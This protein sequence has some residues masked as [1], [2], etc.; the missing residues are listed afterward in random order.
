MAKPGCQWPNKQ[1]G[2][3]LFSARRQWQAAAWFGSVVLV[4]ACGLM[5][6]GPLLA[7]EEGV[8]RANLAVIYPDIGEPYRSVFGAIIEGVEDRARGKV[9]GISIPMAGNRPGISE[10]LRKR[11]VK[12]V[13]ALG[14]SGLK[15]AA[16]LDKQFTVVAGGVLSVPE[17]EAQSMLVQ[18][19]APEPALLFA[20]LKAFAPFVKRVVVVH[21]PR[22]N[23]WLIRLAREAARAQSL[24]LVALEAEDLKSAVRRYQE[25]LGSLH[26]KRDALWLPQDTTTVEDSTV[27]PL[28]LRES[29]GQNLVV[30]SSNA[31]HVRRGVLFSLYPD[32][33]EIGRFLAGAALAPL[34]PGG[35]A[36]RGIQALKQ[37]LTAVNTRTAEH[38]GLDLG[39]SQQRIHLVFPEQ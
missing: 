38:L 18:S 37:V 30:F 2:S 39:A 3:F 17:S 15:A 29:W 9:S 4:L 26:P 27:L 35:Q 28:V 33:V 1:L 7:A 12:A 13:I 25:Q 8:G 11:D 22:Q 32:N 10:E 31:M 6:A 23:D 16:N 19:L 36:P 14:R 21:D 24:E 34:Q 20:K 5:L